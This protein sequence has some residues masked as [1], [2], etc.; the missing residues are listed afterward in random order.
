MLWAN[1]SGLL[2][3]HIREVLYFNCGVMEYFNMLFPMFGVGDA[4]E[5][6]IIDVSAYQNTH[7]RIYY[8]IVKWELSHHHPGTLERE[9]DSERKAGATDCRFDRPTA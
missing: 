9:Y 5:S 3:L 4:D 7:I 1:H 2:V 6:S 8:N